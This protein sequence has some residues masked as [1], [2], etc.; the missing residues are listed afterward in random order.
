MSRQKGA[1]LIVV[2]SLLT[3][4]L[5]VGLT[6]MQSSQLDER[7]AGNYKAQSQAQMAAEE[8]ASMGFDNIESADW[9]KAP[10]ISDLEGLTWSDLSD[11]EDGECQLPVACYY[12][13]VKEG[14]EEYIIA[15]GEVVSSGAT[16]NILVVKVI[17]PSSGMGNFATTS[18]VGDVKDGALQLPSSSAS[19]VS[20]GEYVNDDGEAVSVA[21]FMIEFGLSSYTKE[22]VVKIGSKAALTE[23]NTGYFSSSVQD[24]L[25]LI[26]RMYDN[27]SVTSK[28]D[29]KKNPC[30]GLC[31]YDKGLK[32]TGNGT[33]EGVHIVLD[34]D[35]QVGGNADIQGVLIVLN[36]GDNEI[37]D[38][39]WDADE[40]GEVKKAK[41]NGGGNKGTVWFDSD[42]VKA[43]LSSGGVTLDEFFGGAGGGGNGGGGGVGGWGIESWK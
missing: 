14:G 19:E 32:H 35:V 6:S 36:L 1:A 27:N 10:E 38:A 20:E 8:A 40:L 16:S 24:R 2:L 3:V 37:D 34:G 21:S 4:S 13:Y 43:A 39:S 29:A 9:D 23:S 33:L 17:P 26:K 18:L 15:A 12:K 30:S 31:F 5:M 41:L 28:K 22:S 42:V 7:L 11:G 25:D